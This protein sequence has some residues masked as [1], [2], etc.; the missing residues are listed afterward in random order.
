MNYHWNLGIVLQPPY[1]EWLVSGLAITMALS[2]IAWVIALSIGACVAVIR[3]SDNALIRIAG[4]LY[5]SVF[6]NI[7][8]LLQLFVWFF[9]VPEL[10]PDRL[11]LFVKRD[12]PHAEFWTAVCALGFYTSGRLAELFK[13]GL[14]AVPK[15]QAQAAAASGMT[16]AQMLRFILF[17]Q[18]LR[19]ILPALT[20]EFMSVVKNSSLALTIGVFEI[21]AQSRQIDNYTFQ[22]FEAYGAATVLYLLI[23]VLLT[24]IMRVFDSGKRPKRLPGVHENA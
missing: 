19:I 20:S 21:T 5:V 10:L 9:V 12:L 3:I 6:R 2:M 7:P 14:T 13:A 8:L 16:R 15:G 17:P 4:S 1:A 18:C 22:G 24:G 11:G 23:G